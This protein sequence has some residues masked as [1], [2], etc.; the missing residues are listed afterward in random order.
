MRIF[1]VLFD[2]L[3][4][5]GPQIK[6]LH[7][8]FSTQM[9]IITVLISSKPGSRGKIKQK[10]AKD[11]YWIRQREMFSTLFRIKDLNKSTTYSKI[12]I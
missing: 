2:I 10:L 3:Q 7:S 1:F 9:H 12:W 5:V 6:I 4:C 11:D 8:S